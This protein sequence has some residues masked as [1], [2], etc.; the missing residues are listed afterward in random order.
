MLWSF[1]PHDISMVLNLIT[2]K[3]ISIEAFGGSYI[4]KKIK[5]TSVTLLKF[6]KILKLTY[7]Y[8]G[9]TL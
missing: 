1:A 9:C 2:E 8:H 6:K 3:L 4:N 5:D 7:S